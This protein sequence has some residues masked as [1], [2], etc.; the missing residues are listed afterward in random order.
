VDE[1]APEIDALA[2][3]I[4]DGGRIEPNGEQGHRDVIIL[5]AIYES[6]AK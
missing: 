6:A 5:N 4:Q 2:S 3:A 1:F